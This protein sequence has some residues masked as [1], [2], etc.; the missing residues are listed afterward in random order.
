MF[1]DLRASRGSPKNVWVLL[2]SLGGLPRTWEPEECLGCTLEDTG[3]PKLLEPLMPWRAPWRHL[4]RILGENLSEQ[5]NGKSD[6]V[7][8]L[9]KHVK[10][11]GIRPSPAHS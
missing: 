9:W 10:A 6:H 11:S 4:E 3:F 1:L 7:F 8:E 5:R 2:Q